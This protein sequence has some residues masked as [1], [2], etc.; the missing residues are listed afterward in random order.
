MHF[1][2]SLSLERCKSVYILLISSRVFQRVFS[3]Y[4]LHLFTCKNRRR[5]SQE[6]ALQSFKSSSHPGNLVTY[7]YPTAG[8]RVEPR[9]AAALRRRAH[10]LRHLAGRGVPRRA[11][12]PGGCAVV[13]GL[14]R[15]LHRHREYGDARA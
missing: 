3:I 7:W 14:A 4:C 6:R 10:R 2:A 5:Y 8:P 1:K 15:G 13:A 9:A 12:R 11:G